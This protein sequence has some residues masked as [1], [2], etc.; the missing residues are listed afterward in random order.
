MMSARA[1]ILGM[2]LVGCGGRYEIVRHATQSPIGERK[3]IV[4]REPKAGDIAVNGRAE[5]VFVA[6]LSPEQRASWN[7]L[8]NATR[9]GMIDGLME[10][11][12]GLHLGKEGTAPEVI[13]ELKTVDLARQ[14]PRGPARTRLR[15]TLRIVRPDG[16]L[17][18]EVIFTSVVEAQVVTQEAIE[19]TRERRLHRAGIDLGTQAGE[20]LRDRAGIHD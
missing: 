6:E 2:L 3:E 15:A 9:Q 20:Y 12:G 4:V 13:L 14:D 19:A 7:Q 18:D 11:R 1:L 16:Q 10:H 8:L 17:A 5:N